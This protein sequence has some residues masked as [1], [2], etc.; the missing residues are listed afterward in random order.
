MFDQKD[1]SINFVHKDY[2]SSVI[3]FLMS[4]NI[5]K[6]KTLLKHING[7]V[8]KLEKAI[9]YRVMMKEL[10]SAAMGIVAVDYEGAGEFVEDLLS[11]LRQ[12]IYDDNPMVRYYTI[13]SVVNLILILRENIFG[14][15]WDFLLILLEVIFYFF[16]FCLEF[17]RY[18]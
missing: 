14:K 12:C 11:P 10:V 3:S 4:N 13:E 18:Q 5:N 6:V 9:D 16:L 2:S 15:M 17:E 1:S 8:E 7:Q